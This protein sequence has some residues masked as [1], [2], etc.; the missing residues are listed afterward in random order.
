MRIIVRALLVAAFGML[1]A[2]SKGSSPTEP[3][4]DTPAQSCQKGYTAY[5]ANDF[6]GAI[7]YFQKAVQSD[8]SYV[9][10]YEGMGWSY[11]RLRNFT[12][13]D[14]NFQTALTKNPDLSTTISLAV[15]RSSIAIKNNDPDTVL[16]QLAYK[17][18]GTDTWVHRFDPKVTA[19]T[20]HV[21][22]AE[23][24]IMKDTLGSEA[25]SAS[26]ARDAWGQVK[27]ALQLS[28]SDADALRL[29][30]YLRGL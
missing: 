8:A 5:G 15:G 6:A 2:C 23:A 10:G 21:L 1:C 25:G 11:L 16:Q 4:Q 19:V 7:T 9:Y 30:S 13:A 3:V 28:A 29:Q 14:A 27:K 22:L 12:Q 26:N 18:D 20:L 17:I 24:Y